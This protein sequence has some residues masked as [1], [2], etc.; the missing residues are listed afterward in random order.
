MYGNS[1]IGF[2]TYGYFDNEINTRSDWYV[3]AL[4]TWTADT[5]NILAYPDSIS[6]TWDDQG[7]Q[8]GTYIS[9]MR[10]KFITGEEPLSN[11]DTYV[12][13]LERLGISDKVKTYQAA[14]DAYQKK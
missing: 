9:S 12:A 4:K 5:S 10:E 2:P 14:Y 13:E 1:G 8:L 7:S 11:F 3:N 6:V